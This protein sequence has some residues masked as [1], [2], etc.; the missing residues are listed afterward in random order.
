MGFIILLQII[1]GVTLFLHQHF[2]LSKLDL[3]KVYGDATTP[4]GSWVVVTGASDGIGAE[5]CRQLAK[6]GFNIALV[7]RT[8]EKLKKVEQECLVINAKIQT[9]I[10]Q[11]DFAG[12]TDTQFYRD[13]IYNKLED[14]DIAILI[15]NAGVMNNGDFDRMGIEKLKDTL[16]VDVVHVN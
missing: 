8:M 3:L 7:S 2:F 15:N 12:N 14:L 5:Y 11:V 4:G 16:D 10:V 13:Q 1:S 6:D 9:R